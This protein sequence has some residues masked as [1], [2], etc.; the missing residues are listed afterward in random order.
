MREHTFLK[1]C[2]EVIMFK[3]VCIIYHSRY[4]GSHASDM[5][6]VLM[7]VSV[8]YVTNHI[9]CDMRR[10]LFAKK[11]SFFFCTSA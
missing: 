10:H 2:I 8:A 9:L 11:T 6:H 7:G 1:V 3:Y 5:L 4:D